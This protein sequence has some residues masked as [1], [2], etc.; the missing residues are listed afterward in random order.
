MIN[1]KYIEDAKKK[2]FSKEEIKI[3]QKF[4]EEITD[5]AYFENI[6]DL[7]EYQMLS[8]DNAMLMDNYYKYYLKLD[9]YEAIDAKMKKDGVCLTEADTEK[10]I[11]WAVE[12]EIS[13]KTEECW[14][15]EL[16]KDTLNNDSDTI[17]DIRTGYCFEKSDLEAKELNEIK[18]AN[19]KIQKEAKRILILKNKYGQSVKK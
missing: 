5:G 11:D 12:N 13:R 19:T 17:R 6:E 1:E 2:L 15:D 9:T 4:F 18:S 3:K 14:I 10:C 16:K 7:A 8:W